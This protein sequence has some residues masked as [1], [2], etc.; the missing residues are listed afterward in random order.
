M[1]LSPHELIARAP[2]GALAPRGPKKRVVV[3]GAGLAGLSAA[4]RLDQAGHEVTVLEARDRPGGRVETLRRPFRGGLYAEAGAVFIPPWHV[5]V[6]Y[7]A[8]EFG[9]SLVPMPAS[10]PASTLW[11]LRGKRVVGP[12]HPAHVWPVALSEA[13]TR[14]VD[15]SKLGIVALFQRYLPKN[16]LG[17]IQAWGGQAPV[18]ETLRRWDSMSFMGY[19]EASG[20]SPGA[21]DILRLGY[22]DLW[23]EGIES[24]SALFL[25]RDFAL[26]ATPPQ[27]RMR[28]LLA[29]TEGGSWGHPA[30][31][32]ARPGGDAEAGSAKTD[33]EEGVEAFTIEGGNERLPRA[34]ADRLGDRIHYGR[35]V[36][37]MEAKGSFVDVVCRGPHGKDHYEADRVVCAVPF[38]VLREWEMDPPFSV[39]KQKAIRDLPQ[40]MVNRTYVPTASRTWKPPQPVGG[41]TRISYGSG[42]TD[43]PG[44]WLHDATAFQKGETGIL[45]SYRTGSRAQAVEGMDEDA[46]Y[47]ETL[48]TMAGVYPGLDFLPGHGAFKSW[49]QDPWALGGYCYFR[50]G[51]MESLL[52]HVASP[53]GRV[54]FAGDHTSPAPGWME[55]ALQSGH[56]AAQEVN[57]AE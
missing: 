37:A 51:Q 16:L 26:N 21:I 39:N 50:P 47:A 24:V 32:A 49:S 48:Q 6:R 22:F 46:R 33:E 41:E 53:E 36:G 43:L 11:Y 45:E 54:H 28:T 12:V 25:L 5:L 29:A 2:E 56:R 35:A 34:F 17:Q 44:Q 10:T 57:E 38:S 9:L 4:F 19:L 14:E 27:L 55:G 42:N 20:A 40:T 7:H 3:V 18:P 31:T 30:P 13:E 1:L 15:E 23:G 8:R 52:P